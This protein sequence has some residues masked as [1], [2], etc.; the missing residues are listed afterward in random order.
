MFSY[1]RHANSHSLRESQGQA[2]VELALT[3]PLLLL[4]LFGVV[5]LGRLFFAYTSITNASREGARVGTTNPT[6]ANNAIKTR[7]EQE[8]ASSLSLTDANI[9]IDCA[10]YSDTPPYTYSTTYCSSAAVGDRIRVTVNYN[11][12]FLSLYLFGLQ[13]LLL[14]NNTSMAI[15]QIN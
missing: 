6:N 10:A 15:V 14:S 3:L 13:N 7:V 5:D 11:Y 4:I 8:V 1:H 9:T 2:M 12:Q